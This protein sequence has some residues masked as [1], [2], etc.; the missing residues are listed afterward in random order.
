MNNEALYVLKSRIKS[1]L[2]IL[3]LSVLNFLLQF[4]FS[5][6]MWVLVSNQTYIVAGSS[7]K[8]VQIKD[9]LICIQFNTF[10]SDTH[11][12]ELYRKLFL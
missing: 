4:V 2:T 10:K 11:L 5:E 7:V 6:N 8:A 9:I 3:Y 1:G 12:G